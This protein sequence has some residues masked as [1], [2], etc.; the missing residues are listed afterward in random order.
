MRKFL[1]L[2]VL[3]VVCFGLLK[4]VFAT[5]PGEKLAR[6]VSNVLSAVLE[7][8]QN[9]DIEWK[10]SNNAGV[11]IVAGFFKGAFWGVSRAVSGLWDIVSF[12]FPKPVDYGSIIQPE[13]LTR[14]EQTH[15]LSDAK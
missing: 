8:P 2:V 7:V 10:A 12:P 3:L 5:E 6:G 14:G 9:I 13:Y 15:F 1:V 11:G 4:P